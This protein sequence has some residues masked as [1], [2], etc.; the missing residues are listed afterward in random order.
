M[1]TL[2]LT[3]TELAQRGAR[4]TVRE[5]LQQ[6]DVWREAL[7]ALSRNGRA[8]GFVDAQLATPGLRIILTGAGTSAFIGECLAPALGQASGCR[9]DAIATTDIVSQPQK[10]LAAAIPTLV[11]SFARSGNSPE[12]VA[13]VQLADQF[14]DDCRHLVV[15]C[16]ADGALARQVSA[17]DDAKNGVIVLPDATHDRSFAMTSSFTTMLLVTAYCF[18]ATR[19][20]DA[21]IEAA[22]EALA[23]AQER[24]AGWVG[25]FDRVVY[26]GANELKG[27]AREAALK[28]LELSDG[29][30]VSF[31][32][33]PLGFR[34]GPKTLVN[35]RTLVVLF[36]SADAYTRRY[37][38]DLLRELR[39]DARAGQVVAIGAFGNELPAN[40]S[41][42][43]LP[44]AQGLTDLELVPLYVL[45]AQWF[46]VQQSLALGLTP[47]NPSVSGTVNRVVQGV[48]IHAIP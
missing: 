21:L 36:L 48:T 6:P 24:S 30:V 37:D 19:H 16:N 33:S 35:E 8:L 28:L 45:F 4:W 39:A 27:L 7:T 9:I 22:Q 12:S 40:D 15:T 34:H 26:L 1:N 43:D 25:R 13:A 18:G 42:L 41:M 44:G 14:I 31:F 23:L 2:D 20:T 38:M 3:D 29:Q 10:Y 17:R 11:V 5:I 47:D 32:D 46:A